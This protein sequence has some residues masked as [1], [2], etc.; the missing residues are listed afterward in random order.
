MT[1]EESPTL[2]AGLFSNPKKLAPVVAQTMK[3]S[4]TASKQAGKSGEIALRPVHMG[5]MAAERIDRP[6]GSILVRS[7]E[8]LG[9]YPKRLSSDCAITRVETP[10]RIFLADRVD[11]G[12]WRHL[13]YGD[14]WRQAR[15]LAAHL[16]GID[17]SA[18]RPGRHFVGQQHRARHRRARM[19]H[20]RRSLCAD[21][22]ALQ[23]GVAR[24]RQAAPH[25]FA[26]DAAAVFRRRCGCVC[27]GA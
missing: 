17:A 26:A 9:A 20:C 25:C 6:D 5:R 27:S 8:P 23:S 24:F 21:L 22:A 13:S 4:Q 16:L 2:D 11:G 12:Q 19:L 7:T 1:S 15:A 10:E 18:E 14:A 3:P